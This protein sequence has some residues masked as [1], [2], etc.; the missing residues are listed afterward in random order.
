MAMQA[1]EAV[2]A[3]ATADLT[4]TSIGLPIDLTIDEFSEKSLKGAA[5][6]PDIA[7]L[8][9][10]VEFWRGRMIVQRASYKR[11]ILLHTLRR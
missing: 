10:A 2:A 11:V 6:T 3:R 4:P 7:P 1:G 9:L 5:L 8:L